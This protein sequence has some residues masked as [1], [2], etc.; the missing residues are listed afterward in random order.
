[1]KRKDLVEVEHR[2]LEAM[3]D[4]QAEILR[5][6]ERFSRGNFTRM[7]RLQGSD[8]D[9]NERINALEERLTAWKP[10]HRGDKHYAFFQSPKL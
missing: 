3:R 9:L 7:H 5:G 10:N 8:V 2:V 1:V 4:M 6:L